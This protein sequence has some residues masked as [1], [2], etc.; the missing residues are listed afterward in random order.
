MPLPS[1]LS[2]GRIQ[3]RVWRPLRLIFAFLL[4]MLLIPTLPLRP[5][6]AGDADRPL[7]THV[8]S[9]CSQPQRLGL[10]HIG[11]GM[12]Q[13][14]AAIFQVDGLPPAA[15]IVNVWLYWNGNDDGNSAAQDDPALFNPL[16]DDGDPTVTLN[17]GQVPNPQRVGGPASWIMP[18]V[19]DRDNVYAY[20]YR[21]EVSNIVVGDG[22]YSFAGL[23]NFDV[24]NNGAEL[25]ILYSEETLP[26]RYVALA[27]GLDIAFG[28]NGPPSGP[29]TRTALFAFD[30]AVA[31][32]TANLHIFVGGAGVSGATAFWYRTGSGPLPDPATF[33]LVPP[34]GVQPHPE[35]FRIGDIFTGAANQN[36]AGYWDS[37]PVQLSIPAGAS[38]L[39]VQV[40]SQNT[41]PV[42]Q[43][44]ALDWLGGT[45][46]MP[47]FC[48]QSVYLPL[49]L[50]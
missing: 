40:E 22:S 24:Y 28:F 9:D 47:L 21:A 42:A 33:S 1:P 29:G 34:P 38:W 30:E 18:G 45:L 31:K 14:N 16:F 39:A 26:L 27:D 32:R 48:A 8:I 10:R 43:R 2:P 19:P 5:A 49:F 46:S 11:L 41:A 15:E 17:G 37:Y 6:Q 23:D 25:V 35:A 4:L 36:G 50:R 3:G 13:R 20:A 44:A 12:D 7:E